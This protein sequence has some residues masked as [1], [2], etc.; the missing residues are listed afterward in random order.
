MNPMKTKPLEFDW[1]LVNPTELQSVL[2]TRLYV[3]FVDSENIFWGIGGFEKDNPLKLAKDSS[4]IALLDH[5]PYVS[6]MSS[7]LFY[8]L[9]S[10]HCLYH[11]GTC[12]EYTDI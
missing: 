12:G 2:D 10:D 8:C 5:L 9:Q 3:C 6:R 11:L 7:N 1:Y 4:S